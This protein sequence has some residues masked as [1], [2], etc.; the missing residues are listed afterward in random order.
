MRRSSGASP[1]NVR[2]WDPA[3]RGAPF[4]IPH[5]RRLRSQLQTEL[6]SPPNPHYERARRHHSQV[7]QDSNGV[8]SRSV[9][10]HVQRRS[11]LPR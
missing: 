5:S 3:A 10:V 8:E 1:P 6:C 9:G 11:G 7:G 2:T 4:P